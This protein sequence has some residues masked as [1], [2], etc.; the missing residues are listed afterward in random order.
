MEVLLHVQCDD[1]NPQ[2]QIVWGTST[3]TTYDISSYTLGQIKYI[4]SGTGDTLPCANPDATSIGFS[5]TSGIR[6]LFGGGP[7]GEDKCCDSSNPRGICNLPNKQNDLNELCRN[8]GY[9]SS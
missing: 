4:T 1:L 6:V 5:S 7:V 3:V 2:T 8:L 9:S